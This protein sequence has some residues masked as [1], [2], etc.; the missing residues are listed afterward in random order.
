VAI[1]IASYGHE[2]DIDTRCPSCDEENAFGLDLRTVIDNLKA[3][4]FE[5]TFEQGDLTFH[6]KPLNYREMTA[7]SLQQFEQQKML[8]Q[9]NSD[10]ST[11]ESDKMTNLNNM[12]RRLVEVTVKAMSQ[13]ITE[14]RTPDAIVT[15]VAQIE[16]FL[17]NCDRTMFNS[18]RD[19]VIKLREDS[20]LRPLNITCPSCQHQY[21]Q[22]FTLDMANFF[23]PAS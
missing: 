14:I 9:I 19:Y 1:R 10:E 12:M 6:F 11:S 23:A 18:I 13:S 21:Q 20:E 2:M 15:D 7:N 22:I 17:N 4:N 16:E 8:Q 5:K 3:G